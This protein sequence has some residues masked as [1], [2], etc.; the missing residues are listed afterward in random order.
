MFKFSFNLIFLFGLLTVIYQSL[1]LKMKLKNN[2][3]RVFILNYSHFVM[4]NLELLLIKMNFNLVLIF[5]TL[6]ERLY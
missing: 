5:I 2:I 4:F 1:F 3:I 6:I